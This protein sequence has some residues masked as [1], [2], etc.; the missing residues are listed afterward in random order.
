MHEPNVNL[1]GH[2]CC[3]LLERRERRRRGTENGERLLLRWWWEKGGKLG[4]RPGRAKGLY[5]AVGRSRAV[6][7]PS[8]SLRRPN[9]TWISSVKVTIKRVYC[10]PNYNR[11]ESKHVHN[12]GRISK[13]VY[14]NKFAACWKKQGVREQGKNGSQ[15]YATGCTGTSSG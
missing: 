5:T 7:D 13:N 8:K 4:V 9:T 10:I 6:G 15:M 14:A 12:E 3:M 11:I 1:S 2:D